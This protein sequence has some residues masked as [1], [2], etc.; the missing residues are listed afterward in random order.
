MHP[1]NIL[2]IL[3]FAICAIATGQNAS[4][5]PFIAGFSETNITPG[6]PVILSGYGG[7]DDPFES[8]HDDIYAQA[9]YLQQGKEE[10]LVITS[11]LIGHSHENVDLL[12]AKINEETGISPQK[13]F[14]TATHSHGGPT[15]GTYSS[16]DDLPKESQTYADS[17]YNKLL[18]ISVEA[19][20]AAASVRIGY[21][22]G[23]SRVNINPRAI[24]SEG[25][26]WLGRNPDGVCDHD[27]DIIKFTEPQGSLRAVH[28]N[29][30]CHGTCTGPTNRKLTEDWPGLLARMMKKNLGEDV[31][32]MATAGASAN[33][34]PIYGPT[35]NF[36]QVYATVY[37]I[38]S[39]ALELIKQCPTSEYSGLKSASVTLELPGKKRWEGHLPEESIPEGATIVRLSALKMG[40]IALAGVSGELFTEI[41]LA[42]KERIS[43][44][45]SIM[46]HC[47][48]AS[49][50]IC[51][52]L[53]Y[54]EG[55][56]EPKVSRL[57]PG[58]E[59][60]IENELVRL[61]DSLND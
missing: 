15:I 20:Q 49:G 33:I 4:V 55:G 13:I 53:S 61:V 56:Y 39:V 24:F 57:M 14:I 6:Q 2:P 1:R 42:V 50:Y 43:T 8:V 19:K 3:A 7:R 36:R 44:K 32:V 30:P 16:R 26:I 28:I 31:T 5:E 47:N 58:L 18:S 25:E 59:K 41:G 29:Y 23:T 46:T 11:D 12:K 52:D 9:M 60:T 45:L 17:L 34:N 40:D 38:G 35:D 27:L 21:N 10:A 22:K 51:T 48:G 54:K 37:G